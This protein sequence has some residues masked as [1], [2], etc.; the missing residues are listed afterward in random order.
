MA[1]NQLILIADDFGLSDGIN[2]AILELLS[3]GRLSGTSVMTNMPH[4]AAGASAL[5]AYHQHADLGLHLTLTL[6]KP[7]SP[8]PQFAPET[9]FPVLG[10]VMKRA[11]TG[12][13]DRNEIVAEI[14]AQIQCF[15]DAL[16]FLPDYIDGH[17]H[18]H[19]LPI[20]RAALFDAITSFPDFKP[21]IRCPSDNVFAIW[22]RGIAIKKS[23]ILTALSFG[24]RQQC[25]RRGLRTNLSF[26]GA[27]DFDAT[28]NFGSAFRSYLKAPGPRHLVMCHPGYVAPNEDLLD[29]VKDTRPIELAFLKGADYGA[30]M[31]EAH[32]KIARFA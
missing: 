27:S 24:F 21:W 8:M 20:V 17:Q 19:I 1:E 5:K 16:G 18:V 7:L 29:I 13:L 2:A 9:Q 14:I 23:L 3:L 10:S 15:R 6:G 11:F 25:K 4:F 30:I 26:S 31:N 28:Q 12:R 32:L 22:R